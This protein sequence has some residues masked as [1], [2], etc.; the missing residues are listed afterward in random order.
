MNLL[1]RAAKT[2]TGLFE[3][4]I[5]VVLLSGI[6]GLFVYHD[7]LWRWDNLLYDAQLSFWNRAV[8]EDIII[9][10]IDDESLN[11]LGH[12]PWPRSI[13]A[14]LINQLEKESPR[15]IGLDII[16]NEAD[17]DHPQ[18][19]QLL[20]EAIRNSGKVVLPVFMS[21]QSANSYPIE[22]LPLPELTEHAAALGHV[23]VDIGDDGIARRVY[24]RE[25]IGKPQWLHYS[26]AILNATNQSIALIEKQP[27]SKRNDAESNYSP[28]QWYR[29]FP[30]LIPYAGPPGHFPQIGYSQVLS[31]EYQK[32]LFQ[33]KIVLI[34]TTA[35][36]LGD[37]L[38]T[39][40]AGEG[41]SMPGV[42]IVANII[43]AIMNNLRIHTLE[44]PW[45]IVL[46]VILVALPI[47]VYPYLNPGSTLIVLFGIVAVTMVIVGMLLWLFGLWMPIS[48]V[49]LFQF[50]SYPL[51]SW[52]RL[53]VAMRHINLELNQLSEKQKKLSWQRE[54]NL[55]DEIDFLSLFM[56]IQGWVLIDEQGL[57]VEQQG[58]IPI[59]HEGSL[60][61][62]QWRSDANNF[63]AYLHLSGEYYRLGV[64]MDPEWSAGY[65]D[66]QLLNGLIQSAQLFLPGSGGYTEDIVEA[67][68]VQ[69]QAVGREYEALRRIIDDSLSGMADGVLICNGRG[70]V[71]FSNHRAGWYLQGDDNAHLNGEPVV[72]LL[73]KVKLKEDDSWSSLLQR[74]LV[75]HER[76]LTHAQ[77]ESG[78]DL[79]IE[80]S[81]LEIMKES[82][83]GFIINFSDISLLKAS[84][85]KRNEV[86]DFLSHDLRAP[87]SSILAM[88]E[89][90]KNKKD[91]DALHNML[92]DMENST[93]KTLH[94]A[95][96]FLQLSRA[97]THEKI[98]FQ[99]VDYIS[100][101]M[102]AIDQL[103]G[104]SNRL[105]VKIMQDFAVAELWINAE[106]DLLE[107]AVVNLLSN[108]IKHSDSGNE[109]TVNVYLQDD[110]VHCCVI[111][112]GCG[113]SKHELP[114][115]FE[116][117]RRVQGAGVE[118]KQGV[119]LGLAFVDAVAKRHSG[120]VKV[121][122][123][124]GKGS[125]F[126]LQFPKKDPAEPMD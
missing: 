21:R 72:P 4:L 12:W 20:E 57:V 108:A 77:H 50:I 75:A 19:D 114:H 1:A 119:G 26:L 46:A 103:W 35:E 85:R 109:V 84:E 112:H 40:H 106:P 58:K 98:N 67:K 37:A 71:L 8:S 90:A 99:D 65:E 28:L 118:R 107:R 41:G 105:K 13:H 27:S 55:A 125:R 29:E 82:L 126:C 86:L 95:E 5:L 92:K 104:L 81:P 111:D 73:S 25:G 14:S 22:E 43:D 16:F 78:R 18:S 59:G 70:Q 63:W 6:A 116:M 53:E 39:P 101:V 74:V 47:L 100:V 51:W 3:H 23:H 36:G 76:V 88:I 97:N 17:A 89:I 123:E 83:D 91:M 38:P 80:I 122:S 79:M 102:N 64:K 69:V 117:F 15:I 7:V 124:L 61:D 34:G 94:L 113:I 120:Q 66:M 30:F 45:L 87:L 93:H 2:R 62:Y 10:A 121:E 56:P 9:I 110:E 60:R 96:Q 32:N 52:R 11:Q 48:T 115:L 44:R 31:G 33:D 54:R 42:E 49:V 68:V 24:L